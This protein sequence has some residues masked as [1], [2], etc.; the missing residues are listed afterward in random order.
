M[1]ADIIEY[2]E[3]TLIGLKI[4]TSLSEDKTFHL[5]NSF[6]KRRE[7]VANRMDDKY[8]SIQLY[9][10]GIGM[11]SFTPITVFEKWAAV[12]VTNVINIPEEMEVIKITAGMYAKFKHFGTAS[13]FFRTSQYIFGT[14][15]PS[16]G[17]ELRM[18][19]HFEIMGANYL[20]PNDPKSE[21]DVYIPIK[22]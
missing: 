18:G 13:D 11:D 8:Y 15:L 5:W 22:A 6:M 2:E 7:E 10:E 3:L 16:S 9:P 14:W 19:H 4:S 12:S 17:Y 1:K 21:E 20:G